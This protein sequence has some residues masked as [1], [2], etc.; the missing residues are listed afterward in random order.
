MT[1]VSGDSALSARGA[2]PKDGTLCSL[3][4]ADVEAV[5]EAEVPEAGCGKCNPY[6]PTRCCDVE[7]KGGARGNR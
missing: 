2:M 6:W 3:C 7:P 5:L 1:R 4:G